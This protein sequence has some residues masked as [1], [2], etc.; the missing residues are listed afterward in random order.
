MN[1]N[2]IPLAQSYVSS[3]N[4]A[5]VEFWAALGAVFG[6]FLFFRGFS[7]L[8]MKRLILNTPS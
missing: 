8:R 6:A 7:M 1:R 3:T 4:S 5:R 2:A